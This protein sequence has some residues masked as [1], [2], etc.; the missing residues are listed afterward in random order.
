MT[1]PSPVEEPTESEIP[2]AESATLRPTDESRTST[3][4][5]AEAAVAP[6]FVE[7][8]PA[9]RLQILNELRSMILEGIVYPPL[10]RRRGLEGRVVLSLTIDRDGAARVLYIGESSGHSILDRAAAK[11]VSGLL[12]LARG[13]SQ[14]LTV[15]IP[16]TYRLTR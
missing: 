10:A 6:S 8:V 13:P 7:G 9:E 11:L 16:I 1:A 5:R 2:A 12:P 15:D 4:P 3:E 14:P